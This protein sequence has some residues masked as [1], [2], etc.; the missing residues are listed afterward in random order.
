MKKK[1][2][3]AIVVILVLAIIAGITF[4]KN[5]NKTDFISVKSEKELYRLYY[6]DDYFGDSSFAYNLK[7]LLCMPFSLGE[8]IGGIIYNVSP[9]TVNHEDSG[10]DETVTTEKDSESSSDVLKEGTSTNG[11]SSGTNKD[12]S[13]TNIQVEN[14]DEADI[15][16]TDGDY[17]YS[18][19]NDKVVI[20]NVK[21]PSKLEI[22]STINLSEYT[23]VDLIL[24]KNQLAVICA[25]GTGSKENTMV[26]IYDVNNHAKPVLEKSYQINEPYY[27]SRTVNNKLYVI[28]TGMMRTTNKIV[29]RTYIENNEEKKI[30]LDKIK[31]SKEIEVKKQSIISTVDLNDLE[32]DIN[33]NSYLIDISNVYVS[34][35][36][37]YLLDSGYEY[38]ENELE[39]K[40]LFTYK[41]IFGILD[42]LNYPSKKVTK[43][44]KFDIEEDGNVKYK[45]KT[46][47]EG[48][49]INQYSLDEKN[50]HLRVALFDTNGSKVEI[51]DE[52]LNSIGKT[53]YIAKGEKMYSSRFMGDKA[54]LVT[55]QTVDPLFVID[56]SDET[57]PKV[58]GEL[59]I[60]G[61][62]TYLHP[63]DEN[64]LIGI[65]M[66]TKETVNRDL[67][68]KVISKTSTIVGMKMALFDVSDIRNPEQISQTVI[69]DSKTTSAILTNPKALLFSKEKELI[70]IPVNNYSE[71]F[72]IKSD[73]TYTSV[74]NSY[75]GYNKKSIGEGYLVYKIN[76]KD[77]IQY[78][79]SIKHEYVDTKKKRSYVYSG[80]EDSETL[81]KSSIIRKKYGKLIRG[82]YIDNNLYTVSEVAVKVNDLETLK[83]ISSVEIE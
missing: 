11:E 37:I 53:S 6:G 52:K 9:S 67:N 54:Y 3:I 31:Y 57:D 41:G 18:I 83:E 69:G 39:I 43:I 25:V 64:H 34:Q 65:G 28:S 72:S 66:E 50:G 81:Y 42:D 38:E 20:T 76:L 78:K 80:K 45:A 5:A 4:K 24:N 30:P 29:D 19:S 70:A 7:L 22:E 1:V 51:L 40:D 15:T 56:L 2:S 82:I 61:Y 49:T 14:V 12:Y 47:L 44:L 55:Y 36:S 46:K 48:A 10:Y 26:R 71:D 74:I 60:P 75:K 63:Y 58:K 79:G 32:K 23:P 62:S 59:H 33:I 68:G 21:N 73:D 77:G 35:N 8:Q 16:K 27:T 13:T 17:I